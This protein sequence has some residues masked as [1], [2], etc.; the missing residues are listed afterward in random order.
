M[1]YEGCSSVVFLLLY[2]SVV[3]NFKCDIVATDW[4]FSER[5]G[6]VL[7]HEHLPLE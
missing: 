2:L 1:L 5:H 6:E 7:L 3:F 4:V